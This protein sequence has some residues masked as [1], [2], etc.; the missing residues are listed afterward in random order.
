MLWLVERGE[1]QRVQRTLSH[2][3]KRHVR[4]CSGAER[5]VHRSKERGKGKVRELPLADPLPHIQV[6]LPPLYLTGVHVRRMF[7]FTRF[8]LVKYIELASRTPAAAI[9][10][11]VGRVRC[12]RGAFPALGEWCWISQPGF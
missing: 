7:S 11:P 6:Y 3:Q 2:V 1:L 12:W 8:I 10:A 5:E 9:Y 4:R